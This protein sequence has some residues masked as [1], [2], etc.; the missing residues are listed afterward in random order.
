MK[1]KKTATLLAFF[2][3]TFGVHKFYLGLHV[4]GLIFLLLCFTGASTL[5]ALYDTVV[6]LGMSPQK[7]DRIYNSKHDEPVLRTEQTGQDAS[8]SPCA[9][10]QDFNEL[11]ELHVSGVLTDEEFLAQKQRLLT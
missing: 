4:Q 2:L 6:F 8:M 1:R 7:F 10:R 9:L 11:K 5:F 3:G